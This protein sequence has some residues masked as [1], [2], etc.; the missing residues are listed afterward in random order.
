[1]PLMKPGA[2]TY[3]PNYLE[4]VRS[5]ATGSRAPSYLP[6]ALIIALTAT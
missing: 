3:A 2:Y 1:M 4:W 6:S 5:T